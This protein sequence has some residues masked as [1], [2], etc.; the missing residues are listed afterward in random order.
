[1]PIS[2]HW[3]PQTQPVTNAQRQAN[4]NKIG[5][6]PSHLAKAMGTV[7]VIIRRSTGPG[8][9]KMFEVSKIIQKVLEYVRDLN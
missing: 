9:D 5:G 6:G 8:F 1:M 2:P 7:L 3:S 4:P